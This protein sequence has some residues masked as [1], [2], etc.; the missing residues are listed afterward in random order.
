MS[1]KPVA[2]QNLCCSF[3]GKSQ[4][5]VKKLIAGPTV[6]ICDQCIGLCN[7]ILAEEL[8]K[9]PAELRQVLL[10]EI[11]SHER[12]ARVLGDVR[13]RLGERMP[14]SIR[15]AI[16]LHGRAWSRLKGAVAESLPDVLRSS[17]KSAE[18]AQA[19]NAT[20]LWPEISRLVAKT[21]ALLSATEK[22]PSSLQLEDG[23]A[24][25]VAARALV[26][27]AHLLEKA[28]GEGA[29]PTPGEPN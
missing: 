24:V 27:V 13:E 17:E 22:L 12:T 11:D 18:P 5:E 8:I 10:R 15:D 9:Y 7:D 20:G 14:A 2:K 21:H 4:A 28:Q 26:T 6:Y 25:V 1:K 19:F 3:C 16:D 23:H 29:P